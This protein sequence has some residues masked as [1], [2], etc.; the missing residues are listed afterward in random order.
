MLKH[1]D[2]FSGIGGFS[3]AAQW[4]CGIQT[5]QFVEINRW[6]RI[7]LNQNFPG[8]PTHDDIATFTSH[9]GEFD[10]FT[11]GFP[12][13]DLSVAGNQ[14]GI[15]T[16]TRSGLFFEIVRLICECRPRY[17]LLENVPALLSS[18]GGRD[19]GTVLWELSQ[20][21]YDAEWQIISANA[22][23]ANHTRERLWIIAYPNSVGYAVSE[24]EKRGAVQEWG[25]VSSDFKR[26]KLRPSYQRNELSKSPRSGT[27]AQSPRRDDGLPKGVDVD[28]RL[29]ALGNSI[30]PH[31]AEIPIQRILQIEQYLKQCKP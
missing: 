13:Q 7:L 3:L 23:G 19:M 16:G 2:L 10:L 4:V 18:N 21:G 14:K 28:E 22:L 27:I 12:C 24:W 29:K 15:Q 9:R 20:L 8:I 26:E 25:M 11:G 6:C 5:T 1:L 30:V 17:V 31:C